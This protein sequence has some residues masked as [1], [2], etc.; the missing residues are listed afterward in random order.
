[1]GDGY[2][3]ALDGYLSW[4]DGIAALREAHLAALGAAERDTV[5]SAPTHVRS[6][7][8]D[9]AGFAVAGRASE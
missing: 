9:Q 7:D 3:A 1:M 4:L 8:G 5:V 6:R 2:D